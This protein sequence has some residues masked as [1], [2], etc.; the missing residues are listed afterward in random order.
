MNKILEGLRA[1][2][3]DAESDDAVETSEEEVIEAEAGSVDPE[4]EVAEAIEEA[5]EEAVEEAAEPTIESLTAALA[6][7]D[8][9]IAD[10]DRELGERDATIKALRDQLAS[11]VAV[12]DTDD[13][14]AVGTTIL[15]D[16]TDAESF[17]DTI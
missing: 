9:T 7:R 10:R 3:R 13:L 12:F 14:A 8:A 15:E 4:V 5:V 6:E 1:L 17:F 11:H 16:A 2:L